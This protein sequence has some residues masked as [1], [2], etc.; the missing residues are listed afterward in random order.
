M[1]DVP[2]SADDG[3]IDAGLAAEFP[4]LRLATVAVACVPGASSPGLREQLRHRSDR[5][6]GARAVRLRREA[7]P[8][9]YRVFF[10]LVGLDPDVTPV[11]AEQAARDRLFH[12]DYRSAGLVDDAL[13]LALVETGV[14]VYAVDAATLA[15]PL[16]VR[17]ARAG[18]RLGGGPYAPDLVPGRLVLADAE[19]P[20]GVLFGAIAPEHRVTGASRAL[21]LVAIGVAGV[22]RIC[23]EEALFGCAEALRAG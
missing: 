23:V 15:G 2:N 9:A 11:P 19:R 12:G 10:R 7:V 5:M 4:E 17:P 16:G 6:T 20:V 1:S 3:W 21:R 22:P 8:S 13:L 18:E 14:P